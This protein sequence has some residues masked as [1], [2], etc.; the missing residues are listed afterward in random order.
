VPGR[1]DPSFEQA[2]AAAYKRDVP[3]AEIHL[4]DAGHFAID[5]TPDEVAQ[6]P[7][8]FADHLDLAH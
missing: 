2:G 3:G 6:L 4:L 1:Y 5:E 8:R 7:R